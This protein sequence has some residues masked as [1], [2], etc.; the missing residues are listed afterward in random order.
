MIEKLLIL[1]A[2][3]ISMFTVLTQAKKL[4]FKSK[5]LVRFWPFNKLVVNL[6][7]KLKVSIGNKQKI[8]S[9]KTIL[10]SLINT[11]MVHPERP[12]HLIMLY[13][14]ISMAKDNRD[15]SNSIIKSDIDFIQ[16]N[17]D[18]IKEYTC[19]HLHQHAHSNALEGT[20]SWKVLHRSTLERECW[21]D[22][23]ED[24][25]L[26]LLPQVSSRRDS[27][28]NSLALIS[29]QLNMLQ[30]TQHLLIFQ[31]EASTPI[32]TT[33]QEWNLT[34]FLK[35]LSKI[36]SIMELQIEECSPNPQSFKVKFQMEK[37]CYQQLLAI[38]VQTSTNSLYRTNLDKMLHHQLLSKSRNCQI[39]EKSRSLKMMAQ[40]GNS[41][42]EILF[43][44]NLCL[45]SS[46]IKVRMV[47]LSKIMT[48]VQ[49]SSYTPL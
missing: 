49:M 5:D 24:L 6:W 30:D 35:D 45:I 43:P 18:A 17:Q 26:L 25:M 28:K 46:M 11:M 2:V 42:L 1:L 10:L 37:L 27:C 15:G 29:L 41:K 21:L 12:L 9:C 22:L 8:S 47:A 14:P 38:K 34:L 40:L 36:W 44:P 33:F 4:Q 19:L 13:L 3:K 16:M 20:V 39:T 32:N 7:V 48:N 31:Q 23:M